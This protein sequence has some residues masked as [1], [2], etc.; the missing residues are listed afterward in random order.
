MFTVS[1]S[2][3]RRT[4]TVFLLTLFLGKLFFESYHFGM[5]PRMDFLD[6]RGHRAIGGPLAD[7]PILFHDLVMV[8]AHVFLND[9]DFFPR[10]DRDKFQDFFRRAISLQTGHEVLYRD[11]AGGKLRAAAAVYDVDWYFGHRLSAEEIT[12][13][14]I[15]SA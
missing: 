7:T 6:F 1:S 15:L 3:A 5:S 2:S 12:S 9:L 10:Q 11:S 8:F 14:L 4:I 13:F